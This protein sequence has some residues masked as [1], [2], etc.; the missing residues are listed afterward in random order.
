MTVLFVP[1]TTL[2]VAGAYPGSFWLEPEPFGIETAAE[3]PGRVDVETTVVEF[4]QP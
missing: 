3:E 2:I 1:I 4:G